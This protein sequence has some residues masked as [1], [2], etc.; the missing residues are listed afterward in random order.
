[1]KSGDQNES[2][3]VAIARI[4]PVSRVAEQALDMLELVKSEDTFQFHRD[5]RCPN[6][7]EVKSESYSNS[8]EQS[9]DELDTSHT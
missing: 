4:C 5:Y 1:M 8:E 7:P 9:D 3:T 6:K 2:T